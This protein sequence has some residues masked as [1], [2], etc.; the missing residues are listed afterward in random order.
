MSK[1]MN[2]IEFKA[3]LAKEIVLANL[4]RDMVLLSDDELTDGAVSIANKLVEKL[5]GSTMTELERKELVL[6][7]PL[8]SY[9]LS[10]RA[11]N[12]LRIMGAETVGDVTKFTK[13]DVLRRR[14]SGKKTVQ[15]IEDFLHKYGLEFSNGQTCGRVV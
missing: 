6:E 8:N 2:W 15:E 1:E 13:M 12:I 14:N 9:E 7:R 4:A 11:L 10:I 5:S 3:N